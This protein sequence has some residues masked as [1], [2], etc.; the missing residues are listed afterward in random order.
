[1]WPCACCDIGLKIRRQF[2][3]ICHMGPGNGTQVIRRGSKN[4][5]QFSNSIDPFL[6]VFVF[7]EALKVL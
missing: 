2:K 3:G 5:Y 7:D 1:M 6:F 4:P